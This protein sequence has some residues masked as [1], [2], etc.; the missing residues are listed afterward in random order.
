M[1]FGKGNPPVRQETRSSG[2][3]FAPGRKAHSQ[4]EKPAPEN[5]D[6]GVPS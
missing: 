6:A 5:A 1:P 4:F 2:A 3:S